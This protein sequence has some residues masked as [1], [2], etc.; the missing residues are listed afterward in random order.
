MK[1][2]SL[3]YV[4]SLLLASLLVPQ[5]G[6]AH[7]PKADGLEAKVDAY[8]KPLLEMKAFNGSILIA[9]KRQMLLAKGYGM[10]N[11]ELDAPNTP[12]TKFHIASI[13]KTFTAAAVLLLQERGL[14]KV[15]DPL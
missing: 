1:A 13:T 2:K 3:I 9:K 11:Y 5:L 14:L 12:Q 8:V 6:Q 4:L 7:R 10:A 15:S